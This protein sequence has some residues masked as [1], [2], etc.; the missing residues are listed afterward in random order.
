LASILADSS[1]EKHQFIAA[2]FA[3]LLYQ[4]N[5]NDELKTKLAYLILSRTGN[6]AA[7]NH[8]KSLFID[9]DPG[10]GFTSHFGSYLN[11]ELA[12]KRQENSIASFV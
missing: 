8:L 1:E 10:V 3:K 5:P 6:L 2:S 4:L 7:T 9:G 11:I 12:I